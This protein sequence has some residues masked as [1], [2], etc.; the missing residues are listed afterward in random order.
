MS[1]ESMKKN[2]KIYVC[3]ENNTRNNSELFKELEKTIF[4]NMDEVKKICPELTYI[5][6]NHVTDRNECLLKA[7]KLNVDYYWFIDSTFIITNKNTLKNL[8]I[9]NRGIVCPAISK[10]EGLWSNFW[11]AVD[12]EGGLR[13]RLIIFK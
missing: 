11:G 4:E 5:Y 3:V 12:E 8:I 13:I 1:E 9:Q 2:M 6:N 7:N 10:K